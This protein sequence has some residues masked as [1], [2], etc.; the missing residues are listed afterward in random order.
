MPRKPKG[1]RRSLKLKPQPLIFSRFAR[2]VAQLA[3]VPMVRGQAQK[4]RVHRESLP[5][6]TSIVI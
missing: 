3:S 5:N 4:V 2:S 6:P 1:H